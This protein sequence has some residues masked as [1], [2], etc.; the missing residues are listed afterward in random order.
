MTKEYKK[1]KCLICENVYYSSAKIERCIKGSSKGCGSTK[2][3]I[4]NIEKDYTE[5]KQIV[6]KPEIQ[7]VEEIEEQESSSLWSL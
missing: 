7:E 3:V 1:C 4:L 5:E 2:R 6:S